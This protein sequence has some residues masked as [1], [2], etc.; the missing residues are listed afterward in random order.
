MNCT[1]HFF[2]SS[3]FSP[4]LKCHLAS[5]IDSDL[6]C[7]THYN[8]INFY[9]I[10]WCFLRGNWYLLWCMTSITLILFI[11]CLRLLWILHKDYLVPASIYLSSYFRIPES[12]GRVSFIGFGTCNFLVI[13]ELFH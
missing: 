11:L 8:F 3:D 4:D 13:Q 9:D 7:S 12:L 10:A 6:C 2:L 5:C 1:N